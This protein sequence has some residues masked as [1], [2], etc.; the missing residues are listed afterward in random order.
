MAH[1]PTARQFSLL[2]VLNER[3]QLLNKLLTRMI[4]HGIDRKLHSG[5]I[6]CVN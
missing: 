5:V 2:T 3:C 4:L 1:L 6:L